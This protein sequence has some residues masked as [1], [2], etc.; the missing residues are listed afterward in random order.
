M[1]RSQKKMRS[2][3][4]LRNKQV[5]FVLR[6]RKANQEIQQENQIYTDRGKE[7]IPLWLDQQNTENLNRLSINFKNIESNLFIIRK[8]QWNHKKYV[9]KL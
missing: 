1:L 8:L 7:P 6:S 3:V 5:K 4:L 2:Q 9:K